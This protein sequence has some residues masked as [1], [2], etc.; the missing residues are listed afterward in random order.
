MSSV[1]EIQ[2]VFQRICLAP[3][4][5]PSDLE[6]LHGPDER[7]LLYRRMVRSRIFRMLRNGLPQ[8]SELLG[9]ERF[10]AAAI[11]YMSSGGPQTRFIRDTVQ[12]LLEQVLPT[13]AADPSLPAHLP[14]LARYEALKWKVASVE[15]QAT[16]ETSDELDFEGV[17]VHNP[18]VRWLLL[19]HRVDRKDERKNEVLP[20]PR[21]LL[22][23]RKPGDAKI[24]SYLL[25]AFGAE[26]YDA[27]L[28]P[29]RSLADAVRSVLAAR[30]GEPAAGFVDDMASVLASLVERSIIVGTQR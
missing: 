22:V 14:D 5:D 16:R 2:R 18:T 21:R 1:A 11:A 23:Y 7:W 10:D 12:E 3:E 17:P 30:S 20:E 25:N 26:L 13:W 24:Y 19:S 28:E 8:T 4:P 29:E 9:R 6:Q 27:W 15:W